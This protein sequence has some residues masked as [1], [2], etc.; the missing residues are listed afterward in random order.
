MQSSVLNPP[1]A[2]SELPALQQLPVDCIRQ[3]CGPHILLFWASFHQSKIFPKTVRHQL[4]IEYTH[5]SAIHSNL[6]TWRNTHTD[7]Q[8]HTDTHT[9]KHTHTHTPPHPHPHPH[10]HAHAH[11][12]AHSLSA[13]RSVIYKIYI[14]I[15]L[16]TTRL[17]LSVSLLLPPSLSTV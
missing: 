7:T 13:S 3:G 5:A 10:P 6:F 4:S 14:Y 9:H 1:T 15:Q 8:T 16:Y 17:S 11:A 12:H 2:S